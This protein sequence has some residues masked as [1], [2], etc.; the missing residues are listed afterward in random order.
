MMFYCQSLSNFFYYNVW[1]HLIQARCFVVVIILFVGLKLIVTGIS[2]TLLLL[3]FLLLNFVVHTCVCLVVLVFVCV[4]FYIV[5]SIFI[6]E[7]SFVVQR[8]FLL[9]VLNLKRKLCTEFIFLSSIYHWMY[10]LSFHF[11][12]HFYVIQFFFY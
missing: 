3:L 7:K 4:C 12:H 11:H 5:I 6:T 9:L 8:D 2:V 1:T 10:G